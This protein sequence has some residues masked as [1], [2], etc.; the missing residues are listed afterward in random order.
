M[1]ITPC[2]TKTYYLSILFHSVNQKSETAQLTT[3]PLYIKP[4]ADRWQDSSSPWATSQSSNHGTA[5]DLISRISGLNVRDRNEDLYPT[6]RHDDSYS[7]QGTPTANSLQHTYSQSPSVTASPPFVDHQAIRPP[8]PPPTFPSYVVDQQGYT[9]F[10]SNAAV[11]MDPAYG[12]G[13]NLPPVPGNY[14][15]GTPPIQTIAVDSLP[16]TPS[17]SGF[18]SPG[19]AYAPQDHTGNGNQLQL[20]QQQQ[21]TNSAMQPYRPPQMQQVVQQQQA[22]YQLRGQSYQVRAQANPA[23]TTGM[24]GFQ[25]Q[26]QFWS[27]YQNMYAQ[28]GGQGQKNLNQKNGFRRHHGP[29]GRSGGPHNGPHHANQGH[30]ANPMR[31]GATILSGNPNRPSLNHPPQGGQFTS[32]AMQRHNPNAMNFT[33]SFNPWNYGGGRDVLRFK[34]LGNPNIVKSALLEDFKLNKA[35]KWEL[36]DIFGYI[37]E[38]SAD[39]YGS[40][41]IQQRLEAACEAD[42]QKLFDE[43]LP[44]AYQLMTD[45]FGNY[46]M[47]KLFETSN[48]KQNAALAE[49]MRDHVVDLSMDMY[50]CRVVQK[51]FEFVVPEQ[52]HA[53]IEELQPQFIE[54]V[55]STNANHVIQRL[56]V[57]GA[58]KCLMDAF[59]G[60]IE[61]LSRH[62]YGCRVLQKTFELVEE[63]LKRPLLEELHQSTIALIEDQFGNYVVQSVIAS[64]AP[65]D[66]DRVIR[67][68]KGKVLR[69]ARHKFAS[70][71]IEKAIIR[72]E[73]EDR[74]QLIDELIGSNADG[75]NNVGM[76]L[77]DAFGNFPLQTALSAAEPSQREEIIEIITPLLPQVRNTPVGKRLSARIAQLENEAHASHDTEHSS[78]DLQRA[79]SS[80]TNT[81][82]TTGGFSMSRTTTSST[83][84]NSPELDHQTLRAS[85]SGSTS[86]TDFNKS[87]SLSV[88]SAEDA[89]D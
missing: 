28:Q 65:D 42:R 10:P 48:D 49:T 53:L 54:C 17:Y 21:N 74:R 75:T 63:D 11:D 45:V 9:Y 80:S 16:T 30:S 36:Q 52:K 38:F 7:Q 76:L 15:Y 87:T 3:F 37:V 89:L 12:A 83:E 1:C 55:K 47:Q 41:F 67:D 2:A 70:N 40:R 46:V 39:Q 8:P 35:K 73:P 61:D 4:T 59:V 81:S 22:S 84:P 50:G 32:W 20:Q 62:P 69:L 77:R 14:A 57:L 26:T 72:A 5:A 79:L 64:G 71:A 66:R 25:D 34:G 56:I 6:L 58:P 86:K 19:T 85:T 23:A 31:L 18:P 60:Q 24:Y 88:A 68:I 33:S 44:N 82:E 27:P 78:A 43:I 51:A 29:N 13:N